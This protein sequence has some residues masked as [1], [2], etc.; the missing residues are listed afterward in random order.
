MN[1]VLLKNQIK[2]MPSKSKSCKVLLS[3]NFIIVF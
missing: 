2:L 3:L 1:Q